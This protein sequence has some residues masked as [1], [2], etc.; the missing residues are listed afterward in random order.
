VDKKDEVLGV[1]EALLGLKI[2]FLRGWGGREPHAEMQIFSFLESNGSYESLVNYVGISKVCCVLCTEF[3]LAYNRRLPARK[4]YQTLGSHNNVFKNWRLPKIFA[5][6]EVEAEFRRRCS[7]AGVRVDAFVTRC[8]EHDSA[9]RT[10]RRCAESYVLN[11]RGPYQ[12]GDADS[13]QRR[14][15]SIGSGLEDVLGGASASASGKKPV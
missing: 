7:E 4:R 14:R 15:R 5:G 6:G 10:H 9:A 1:K 11:T 8:V 13:V 3:I 2:E 12:T